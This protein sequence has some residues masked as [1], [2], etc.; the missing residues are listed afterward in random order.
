[1]ATATAPATN[2][3]ATKAALRA[4]IEELGTKRQA[5]LAEMVQTRDPSPA[6]AK[7]IRTR[8]TAIDAEIAEEQATIEHLD[9]LARPIIERQ[10]REALAP[11]MAQA[12]ANGRE[13]IAALRA[14]RPILVAAREEAVKLA[15][16]AGR[17]QVLVDDIARL[18]EQGFVRLGRYSS[19]PILPPDTVS[20]LI[21]Q[22]DEAIERINAD[23]VNWIP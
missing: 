22:V 4:R 9:E 6:D 20:R 16:F 11:L 5:V 2:H 21:A 17:D 12:T 14:L 1:M 23:R 19:L 13:A 18:A 7:R 10:T 3:A 15:A 8:L